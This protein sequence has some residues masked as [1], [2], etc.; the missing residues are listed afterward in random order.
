MNK[1]NHEQ[2]LIDGLSEGNEKIFDYIFQ[3]YYSGLVIF[4][5]KYVTDKDTAED[6]VQDFFYRLWVNRE[7]L[8]I[9]QSV[10]SYFFSSVKNRCLDYLRHQ[11]TKEKA[12]VNIM[13]SNSC[14][15][16]VLPHYLVE[17]ELRERIQEALQK[18]PE[19]CRYIFEMNRFDGLTPKEIADKEH[20]SVRTVEGHIGKAL[21]LL[22]TEL[23]PYF[24]ITFLLVVL[25]NFH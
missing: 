7:S 15:M 24:P 17:S 20:I 16:S 2:V 14:E 19:K 12:A 1:E 6:I 8:L 13:D 21:K 11:E 5:M 3:Y 10:K 9:K 18:L 25:E 4:A 23:K 22:R